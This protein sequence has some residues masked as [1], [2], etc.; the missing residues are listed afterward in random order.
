MYMNDQAL[1]SGLNSSCQDCQTDTNQNMNRHQHRK[2]ETP[3]K[4]I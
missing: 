3:D 4:H 1:V 2:T